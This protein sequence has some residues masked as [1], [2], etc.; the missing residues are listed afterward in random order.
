MRAIILD[1]ISSISSSDKKSES[2]DWDEG[3]YLP[4]CLLLAM[5][6]SPSKESLAFLTYLVT[7]NEMV[8]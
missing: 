5:E 7:C 3:L 2:V 4:L 8:S 1:D 6:G